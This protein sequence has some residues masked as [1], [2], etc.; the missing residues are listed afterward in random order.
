[1]Y[2][3]TRAV[4]VKTGGRKEIAG[5]RLE[6]RKKKERD[7]SSWSRSSPIFFFNIIL[8]F[9]LCNQLSIGAGLRSGK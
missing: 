7:M 4:E 5:L 6:V 2:I 8:F 3:H 9:K 1:M